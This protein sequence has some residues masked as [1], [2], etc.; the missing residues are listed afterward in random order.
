MNKLILITWLDKNTLIFNNTKCFKEK[1]KK[2]THNSLSPLLILP[3]WGDMYLPLEWVGDASRPTPSVTTALPL[4]TIFS[5]ST[6]MFEWLNVCLQK[7]DSEMVHRFFSSL[8]KMSS[9]WYQ[10]KR[11]QYGEL[12]SRPY[13]QTRWCSFKSFWLNYEYCYTWVWSWWLCHAHLIMSKRKN[14]SQEFID[15]SDDPED[16]GVRMD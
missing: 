2:H 5:V 13:L 15:D 6:F 12:F 1:C 7:E 14:I 11:K 9:V 3:I 10:N 8:S 4:G 16:T